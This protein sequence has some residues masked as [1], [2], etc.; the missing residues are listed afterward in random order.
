VNLGVDGVV[1][2]AVVRVPATCGELLQGVEADG[3]VLVSLPVDMWG[4]VHV[5]LTPDPVVALTPELPKARAALMLAL[6]R[7]AWHGGAIVELGGEIAHSRGMGSS[8]VDVAGVIAG[9]C[10]AA[11]VDIREDELVRLMTQV[12]PSDTSPLGGLWAI[13]H[14]SGRRAEQLAPVPEGWWL[15]TVDSRAPVRTID[16]HRECGAGPAIPD[17]TVRRTR[18]SNPADVARVATES[19]LR[20]QERLPHVAF[21]TVR[22]IG[23]RI[24]APGVCVA[25][26]GSICAVICSGPGQADDA[27]DAL[28]AEGLRAAVTRAHG[29]GMLVQLRA[30]VAPAP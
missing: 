9:V 19:A 15:T 30:S 8:T 1:A 17:G 13:D 27:R 11:G 2:E 5:G 21:E 4:T 28:A 6:E 22:R 7:V 3:P 23:E 14:V 18:W 12:E 20:N 25:H 26:S 10:R 16:M 29:P 24:G